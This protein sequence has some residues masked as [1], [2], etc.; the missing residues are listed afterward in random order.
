M[1]GTVPIVPTPAPRPRRRS[2]P[3]RRAKARAGVIGLIGT[4]VGAAIVAIVRETRDTSCP[5]VGSA[6]LDPE[7]PPERIIFV[8]TYRC[9]GEVGG[10]TVTL[11][12][13]T[14]QGGCPPSIESAE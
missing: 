13:P 14:S 5:L 4:F 9:G 8:C 6:V 11:Q 3:R 12:F 2:R 10:R 1:S 7:A